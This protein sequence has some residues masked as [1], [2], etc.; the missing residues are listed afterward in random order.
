[1]EAFCHQL[2]NLS[3]YYGHVQSAVSLSFIF[4]DICCGSSHIGTTDGR[5]FTFF[6]FLMRG[7]TWSQSKQSKKA[8]KVSYYYQWQILKPSGK[9][10]RQK[11]ASQFLSEHQTGQGRKLL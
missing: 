6:T 5:S 7:P 9:K 10:E 11:V 4:F 1:L 8:D 2:W 3:P